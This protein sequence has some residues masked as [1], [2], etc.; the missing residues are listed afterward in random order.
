[1]CISNLRGSALPE[2][3]QDYTSLRPYTRFCLLYTGL[4]GQVNTRHQDLLQAIEHTGLNFD[5]KAQ[6]HQRVVFNNVAY[7]SGCSAPDTTSA[8][9]STYRKQIEQVLH[10]QIHGVACLDSS[11][12]LSGSNRHVHRRSC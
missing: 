2:A 3:K 11:M 8:L 5:G 1:M 12:E 4:V 7:I 9:G 10:P 6:Q